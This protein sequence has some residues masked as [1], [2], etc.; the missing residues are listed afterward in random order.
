MQSYFWLENC[1]V[2]FN[3]LYSYSLYSNASH[4]LY[5]KVQNCITTESGELK[6][7]VKRSINVHAWFLKKQDKYN[8]WVGRNSSKTHPG[9]LLQGS[10]SPTFYKQLLRA[11]KDTQV[12]Q[13]F[14]LLGS[15]CV[16]V[17][18]ETSM[19][20][21][22]VAY[23]WQTTKASMLEFLELLG[24]ATVTSSKKSLSC[25]NRSVTSLPRNILATKFPP[26]FKTWVVMLRAVNQRKTNMVLNRFQDC[27][28]WVKNY[29]SWVI[30]FPKRLKQND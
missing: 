27:D 2:S 16:K 25:A 1:L 29:I 15:A 14:V 26:I 12:K 4:K 5:F 21:I 17:P 6:N 7:V 10:I 30:S 19:K 22:P 13:L 18:S 3:D 20:L 28:I 11:Q 8:L 9:I 24:L 23:P